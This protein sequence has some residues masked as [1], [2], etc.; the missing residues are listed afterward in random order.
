MPADELLSIGGV[1]SGTG[2]QVRTVQ[3]SRG[4][5]PVATPRAAGDQGWLLRLHTLA[6][7]TIEVPF[8]AVAVDHVDGEAH[9][10][11]TVPHPGALARIDIVHAGRVV[12]GAAGST[13]VRPQAAAATVEPSPSI[14]WRESAGTLTVGWNAAAGHVLS[15]TWVDATG[16]RR[17]ALALG[18]AGGTAS[19]DTRALPAGGHFEFSLG[20]GLNARTT[21]APR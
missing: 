5:P 18:R 16:A 11:V 10:F 15:A 20:D 4:P 21:V 14:D 6:G 9:F 8:V 13:Q 19:I 7:A 3:A 12:P 1:V 17:I 2:A